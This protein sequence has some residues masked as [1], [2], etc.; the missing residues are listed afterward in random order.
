MCILP[1]KKWSIRMVIGLCSFRFNQ[2]NR[3][4]SLFL[5]A[6]NENALYTHCSL[7]IIV[8]LRWINEFYFFLGLRKKFFLKI[9]FLSITECVC[10]AAH[11][12]SPSL[13][14]IH[15]IWVPR[16]A[17]RYRKKVIEFYWCCDL[18]WRKLSCGRLL[19]VR[20]SLLND[21]EESAKNNM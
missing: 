3:S 20:G 2:M 15:S 17:F 7:E 8:K 4:F 5:I 19:N 1:F 6:S 12:I 11:D 16:I 10:C 13:Q 18:F 14:S 9:S 21:E